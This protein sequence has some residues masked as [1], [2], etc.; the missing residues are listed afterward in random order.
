MLNYMSNISG[1]CYDD[2]GNIVPCS[3]DQESFVSDTTTTQDTFVLQNED[4]VV[5]ANQVSENYINDLT[6]PPP[7]FVADFQTKPV[8]GTGNNPGTTKM[9]PVDKP[10]YTWT[11]PATIFENLF[12]DEKERVNVPTLE[13]NYNY[14]N[15]IDQNSKKNDYEL[16]NKLFTTLNKYPVIDGKV[17]TADNLQTLMQDPNIKNKIMKVASEY[18]QSP[19]AQADWDLQWDLNMNHLRQ[20]LYTENY[21]DAKSLITTNMHWV[22]QNL[23]ADAKA[24]HAKLTEKDLNDYKLYAKSD[25]ALKE[26]PFTEVFDKDKNLLTKE[27]YTINY[28]NG[29]IQKYNQH[30]KDLKSKQ[31]ITLPNGQQKTIELANIRKNVNEYKDSPTRDAYGN[32]IRFNY[33]AYNEARYKDAVNDLDPLLGSSY[34]KYLRTSSNQNTNSQTSNVQQYANKIGAGTPAYKT[35]PLVNEKNWKTISKQLQLELNNLGNTTWAQKTNIE[36]INAIYDNRIERIK[37]KYNDPKTIGV[38][39]L[40]TASTYG[41]NPFTKMVKEENGNRGEKL[42]AVPQY[43]E[44]DY[45]GKGENNFDEKGKPTD[46]AK[47]FSNLLDFA[48]TDYTGKNDKVVY[49]IGGVSEKIPTETDASLKSFFKEMTL[50]IH[51]DA[52]KA[53][54]MKPFG[55]ITFQAVA[56]GNTDMYAYNIKISNPEYLVKFKGTEDVPGPLKD[57]IKDKATFEKL[58]NEGITMYVPKSIAEEMSEK[59]IEDEDEDGNVITIKKFEPASIFGFQ[60]KKAREISPFETR[61]QRS[62][63]LNITIPKAGGTIITRDPKNNTITITEYIE[64]LDPDTGKYV[65][66]KMDPVTIEGASMLDVDDAVVRAKN[67]MKVSYDRNKKRNDILLGLQ[68]IK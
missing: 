12:L 3:S 8:G 63:T 46:E 16:V 5:Y 51:E 35:L 33:N 66:L 27:Q 2:I 30:I 56:G 20:T 28:L 48:N 49:V 10:W 38:Q 21:K 41:D 32:P 39:G 59:Q 65:K 54:A 19:T 44:F 14:L 57:I 18:E 53:Q 60:A 1:D 15:T 24:E 45:R 17:V 55:R 25:K 11:H 58:K 42:Q 6:G 47:E 7:T 36:T 37:E 68:K 9:A 13:Q 52:D 67:R 61:L 29:Q 26:H 40:V 62:N 4:E 34:N 31:T 23:D 43:F 64:S 50:Q 22:A